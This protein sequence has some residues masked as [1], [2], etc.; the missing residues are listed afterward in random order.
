MTEKQEKLQKVNNEI[1]ELLD[2]FHENFDEE[3]PIIQRDLKSISNQVIELIGKEIKKK[4][5]INQISSKETKL[6][7]ELTKIYAEIDQKAWD[8]ERWH[9]WSCGKSQSLT[10]SHACSR[11]QNKELMLDKDNI[12][13][14]C[15]ECHEAW[16]NRIWNKIVNFKNLKEMLFYVLKHNDKQFWELIDGITIF[17]ERELNSIKE[18]LNINPE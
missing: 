18:S 1:L 7:R 3:M 5:M 10:H 15:I 2:Y 9:C 14:Q 17:Y 6:R 16:E 8:E 12:F 13:L 4:N 11:G